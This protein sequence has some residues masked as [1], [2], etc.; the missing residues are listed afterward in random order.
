MGF[1]IQF[2]EVPSSSGVFHF[3]GKTCRLRFGCRILAL[4]A[5]LFGRARHGIRGRLRDK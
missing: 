2:E 5:A 1:R 4:Y 3:S